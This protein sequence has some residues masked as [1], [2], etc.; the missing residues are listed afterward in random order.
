MIKTST[1]LAGIKAVSD[2]IFASGT[3]Q[4]RQVKLSESLLKTAKNI[5]EYY[6]H[7]Q[8]PMYPGCMR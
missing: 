1:S 6:R 3:I 4:Y 5:V 7:G 8:R 2:G